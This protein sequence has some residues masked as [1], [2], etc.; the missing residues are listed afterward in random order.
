MLTA[1]RLAELRSLPMVRFAF[2]FLRLWK[3]LVIA[4]I[5]FSV[6]S[7]LAVFCLFLFGA[8]SNSDGNVQVAVIMAVAMLVLLMVSVMMGLTMLRRGRLQPSIQDAASGYVPARKWQL[9]ITRTCVEATE[10][11]MGLATDPRMCRPEDIRNIS[12]AQ[13]GSLIAQLADRS[14]E[15]ESE[16][17]L[18]G[19]L[20]QGDAD[21][22]EDALSQLLGLKDKGRG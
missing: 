16:M 9:R 1:E 5:G 17:V 20:D 13:D 2:G 12:V 21:W 8:L 4:F 18:T 6:L 14:S 3:G 22:L 11:V 7:I 10:E 15:T 19:P